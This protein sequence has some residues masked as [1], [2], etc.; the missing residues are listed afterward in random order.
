MEGNRAGVLGIN[1][2]RRCERILISVKA[3]ELYHHRKDAAEDVSYAETVI[4]LEKVIEKGWE[5][6]GA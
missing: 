6:A 3:R 5:A 2:R 1:G 4:E